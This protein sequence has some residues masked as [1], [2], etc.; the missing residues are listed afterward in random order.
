MR[1]LAEYAMKGRA[2]AVIVAVV[3]TGSVL[4]AWVGAAIVALVT[5]RKGTRQGSQV[6]LWA[7]L[8]AVILAVMGNIGPAVTLVSVTL[9]AAV[10]RNMQS[11]QW[12]LVIAVCAGT[13]E[14]LLSIGR[15]EPVAQLMS[16]TMAQIASESERWKPVMAPWLELPL[17]QMQVLTAGW[18]SLW[19][20][21][22]VIVCMLLARWWQASLYNPGGFQ[23]EFH[24]LRLSPL[25]SF[26]LVA[27]MLVI[28][29]QGVEYQLWALVF[30]IPFMFAGFALIHGI[31]ARRKLGGNWLAIFYVSWLLLDPVKGLL[32]IAAIV[33]SWVDI[34]SRVAKRQDG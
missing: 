14:G 5:L 25:M 3:A 27:V 22:W 32:I 20:S 2:Q 19:S 4:F 13:L 26:G 33:D 21:F 6:L 31:V 11:W 34:R 17:A 9:A 29:S 16:E 30:T 23:S 18:L 1:A 24:Q 28:S 15:L 10:L 8:P 7:M 12:V